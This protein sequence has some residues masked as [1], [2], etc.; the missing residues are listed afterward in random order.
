MRAVHVDVSHPHTEVMASRAWSFVNQL[1]R[2][3]AVRAPEA[4]HASLSQPWNSATHRDPS[5]DGE[6]R[7][8]LSGVNK[9]ICSAKATNILE[10]AMGVPRRL[11]SVYDA[12]PRQ[13]GMPRALQ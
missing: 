11:R 8:D 4:P 7:D 1:D 3:P 10:L 12:A 6:Q 5:P 2:L 9:C 13:L